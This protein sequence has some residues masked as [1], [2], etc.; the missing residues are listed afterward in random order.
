MKVMLNGQEITQQELDAVSDEL[1]KKAAIF[2]YA[3]KLLK[4]YP[5]KSEIE[6]A[7]MMQEHFE[8]RCLEER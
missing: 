3:K 7:L 6:L 5:E 8:N 1:N 4:E 2:Q